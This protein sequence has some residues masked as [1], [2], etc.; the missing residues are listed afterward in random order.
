MRTWSNIIRHVMLPCLIGLSS[1]TVIVASL[2][3]ISP[4]LNY[5]IIIPL[6]KVRVLLMHV[7]LNPGRELGKWIHFPVY[8]VVKKE[9]KVE[10]SYDDNYCSGRWSQQA[11]YIQLNVGLMLNQRRRRCANIKLVSLNEKF[12][13][14]SI[15]YLIHLNWSL[16]PYP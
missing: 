7:L 12:H 3:Q 9:P 4:W 16:D 5:H 1:K 8:N 15:T 14:F 10:W 6:H 13:L 11:L 2:K